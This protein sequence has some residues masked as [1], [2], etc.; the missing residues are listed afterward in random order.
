MFSVSI[1]QRIEYEL[2]EEANKK[3]CLFSIEWL[4]EK[5]YRYVKGLEKAEENANRNI[6]V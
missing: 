2:N 3:L 6:L 5:F 1:K 4:I